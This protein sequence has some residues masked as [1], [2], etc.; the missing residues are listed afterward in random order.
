MK[1]L[2][3]SIAL[4]AFLLPFLAWA[5]SAI[6]NEPET[7]HVDITADFAGAEVKT[8]GVIDGPG[9]LIIKITGPRQD[10]TLSREVKWG[11]LWI[12]GGKVNVARAPSLLYLYATKPIA[13][14]LPP[15]EQDKYQLRLEGVRIWI[16]PQL[17]E[18][19]VD[20]WRQAF[21]RLKEKEGRY[22]ED[23]HAIKV[24]RNR[25]ILSDIALP[26]DTQIGKYEIETLLVKSGKVVGHD[27]SHFEVR[28]IGIELSVWNA[29]H[30]H[31]WLFGIVCTLAAM[32]LG[33]TM[34]AVSHRR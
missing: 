32:V 2:L 34:N 1:P 4:A 17:L 20:A 22:L 9:D 19:A 14:I 28:Q 8:Y 26:G 13:S 24:I 11:P 12:G 25:L 16:E 3:R 23:D 29:A 21:F 7:N 33:F 30:D 6:V 18:N 5:D 27:V 10:V 15:A 31:S